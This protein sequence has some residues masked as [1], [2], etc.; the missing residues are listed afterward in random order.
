MSPEQC[1]GQPLDRRSD[2][3]SLGIVLLGDV[4]DGR[5]CIKRDSDFENDDRDRQ[6]AAARRRKRRADL[7]PELERD[8]ACGCCRSGSEASLP[9]RRR[10]ASR[11]SRRS[12]AASARSCRRRRSAASCA[13]CSASVPSRGTRSKAAGE[14]TG[15]VTIEIHQRRPRPAGDPF[16][17]N[18][19]QR[20]WSAGGRPNKIERAPA[21]GRLVGG[22]G[23]GGVAAAAAGRVADR[24]VSRGLGQPAAADAATV[25]PGMHASTLNHFAPPPPSPMTS[26][27][28]LPLPAPAADVREPGSGSG[29]SHTVVGAPSGP[30]WRSRRTW[31]DRWRNREPSWGGERDP[32]WRGGSDVDG[33]DLRPRR[34]WVVWSAV[35]TGAVGLI[36]IIMASGGGGSSGAAAPAAIPPAEREAVEAQPIAAPAPEPV[37][38]P[39]AAPAAGTVT[40][41]V[42]ETGTETETENRKKP[43]TETG[44]RNRDRN[45]NRNRNRS[46]QQDR[47]RD[48]S[49]HHGPRFRAC[50]GAHQV[51]QLTH[52][53]PRRQEAGRGRRQEAGRG[54]RQ[55]AGRG[56]R[57]EAGRQEARRQEARRQEAGQVWRCHGPV[58]TV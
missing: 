44:N 54:R 40:G 36:A 12:R 19:T 7:P 33:V 57:Q 46:R 20:A 5:A 48:Q 41:T 50:D 37:A 16:G 39:A 13:S 21:W 15:L 2:V 11:R 53:A 23:V 24:A 14:H 9:D 17:A 32:S 10:A 3:F 4:D 8:R 45:R 56:R 42:T 31:R 30:W 27:V 28:R 47:I 6:R 38:A 35:A 1:S 26:S 49:R 34:R 22:V 43:K 51:A 58:P 29:G 18:S 52:P 55:E 25:P